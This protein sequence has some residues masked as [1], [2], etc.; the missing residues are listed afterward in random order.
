M[1]WDASYAGGG[2]LASVSAI[3]M[4]GVSVAFVGELKTVAD[5]DAGSPLATISNVITVFDVLSIVWDSIA[6][7]KGY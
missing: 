3:I 6:L 4:T 5:Q 2:E 7:Y 1:A